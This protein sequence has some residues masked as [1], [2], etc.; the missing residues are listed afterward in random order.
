MWI[1]VEKNKKVKKSTINSAKAVVVD[2]LG[3]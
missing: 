2:G 1:V 3:K